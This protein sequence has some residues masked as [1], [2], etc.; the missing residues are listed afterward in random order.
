VPAHQ[1]FDARHLAV[2]DVDLGLVLELQLLA[3]EGVAQVILE[4]ES[5]R[6]RTGFL[7]ETKVLR[8][9]R[10]EEKAALEVAR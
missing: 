4:A 9:V 6:K 8:A 5:G 7:L 2:Q 1:R 10:V 3:I